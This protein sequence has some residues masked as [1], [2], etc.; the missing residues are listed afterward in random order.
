MRLALVGRA[1]QVRAPAG[2]HD[3][4]LPPRFSPAAAVQ[5]QLRVLLQGHTTGK[6]NLKSPGGSFQIQ[7]H[8]A[9]QDCPF[10]TA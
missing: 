10:T 8:G 1:A 7:G 6:A 9:Q 4:L 5:T 2:G 3:L